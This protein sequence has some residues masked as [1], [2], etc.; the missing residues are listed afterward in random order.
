MVNVKIKKMIKRI[1]GI[2]CITFTIFYLFNLP[3][4]VAENEDTIKYETISPK[5][6]YKYLFKRLREK[7]T[8]FVLSKNPLR[9][10]DYYS[11]LLDKR[12]AE[13][14]QVVE[15]KDIGNIETTS[16]RYSSTLGELVNFIKQNNLVEM[17][18]KILAKMAEQLPLLE[19]YQKNYSFN[20]AEWRFVEHDIDYLKEYSSMLSK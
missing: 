14:K 12:L 19:S 18:T 10:A 2:I 17:K 16:Q 1:I 20:T 9:K 6:G 7:I 3:V 11:K 5:Y 15:E 13:L 4:V 8:L